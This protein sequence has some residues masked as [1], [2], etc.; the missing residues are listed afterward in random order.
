MKKETDDELTMHKIDD[1]NGNESKSKRKTVK[2]VIAICLAVGVI[3]AY[4][5][6]TSVPDDYVGTAEK[7]GISATK[8]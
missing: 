8:Q 2:I 1:Y 3:F 6:A 5:K 4:F 7:P